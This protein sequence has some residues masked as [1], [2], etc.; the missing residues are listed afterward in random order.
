MAAFTGEPK[1]VA[2][3]SYSGSLIFTATGLLL[4][5][6][7]ARWET[8]PEQKPLPPVRPPQVRVVGRYRVPLPFP[9]ADDERVIG[10][11][12]NHPPE[13]IDRVGVRVAVGCGLDVSGVWAGVEG[14]LLLSV[15]HHVTRTKTGRHPVLH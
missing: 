14:T 9:G 6:G 8:V 4:S 3:N 2:T 12:G 5:A 7:L 13:L 11:H 1:L 15:N 10:L